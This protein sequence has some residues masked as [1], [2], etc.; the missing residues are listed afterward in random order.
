MPDTLSS[1]FSFFK[2][3]HVMNQLRCHHHHLIFI[4][5]FHPWTRDSTHR[6]MMYIVGHV[7]GSDERGRIIRRTLARYLIL[8]QVFTCQAVST[9]VRRRFPTLD[10]VVETGIMTKEERIVYDRIPGSHGK[11]WAPAVW[12]T[13]LV[14]RARKEG[15]IKD[16]I[17]LHQLLEV[18]SILIRN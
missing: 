2:S 5:I 12:F 15:R 8:M 7:H 10:H 3:S 9:S 4:N 16:D 1:S 6:L 14:V 18:T 11:W 17:L 13:N